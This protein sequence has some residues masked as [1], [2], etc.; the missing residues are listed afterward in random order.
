MVY[1][2]DRIRN[3]SVAASETA[4]TLDDPLKHLAACHERIEERLQILER[5][6]LYLRSDFEAKRQEAREALRDAAFRPKHAA[7]PNA[8]RAA[9]ANSGPITRARLN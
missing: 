1:S 9:A 3:S 5:V 6:V 2:L 8:A 4:A 7:A